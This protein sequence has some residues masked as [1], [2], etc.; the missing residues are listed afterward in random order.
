MIV[1]E[2][3]NV[4]TGLQLTIVAFVTVTSDSEKSEAE[5]DAPFLNNNSIH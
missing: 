3:Y 5:D 1:F 4:S 2:A